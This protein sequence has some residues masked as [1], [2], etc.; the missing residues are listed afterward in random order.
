MSQGGRPKGSKDS[1]QRAP[2]KQKS[3]LEYFE[4]YKEEVAREEVEKSDRERTRLAFFSK[5]SNSEQSSSSSSCSSCSSSS[6]CC[7]PRNT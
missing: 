3:A 4:L 6:S 2:P 7:S 5:A 1:Q